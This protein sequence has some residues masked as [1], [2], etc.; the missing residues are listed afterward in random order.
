VKRV[1]GDV[2]M[3]SH[4]LG[5]ANRADIR[6]LR[7][8]E[9]DNTALAAKVERQ[10]RQLHDGF[11][12]RDQVIRRLTEMLARQSGDRP[13]DAD[14][15]DKDESAAADSLL[16][17]LNQRLAGETAR[18]ERSDRR[19]TE[20]CETL[21]EKERALA[22]SRRECELAQ[23]ELELVECH[24][25][26]LAP[27][28]ANGEALDLSG[29]TLLYVGGRAHQVPRMKE[30]IEGLGARFLHHDGGIEHRSGLLPG[31]V[32]RADR[33]YFPIDCVSH[34]AALTIKRL[35]RLSDKAY[36]PLR[37]ASL[38]CLLSALVRS[39]THPMCGLGGAIAAE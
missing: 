21:K 29:L 3:L 19:L 5:A 13:A 26:E 9:Q 11:A 34:D 10:Q 22:A 37:T 28:Q 31:L 24:L 8:L 15:P 7:Q 39:R 33:V 4:L 17:D 20:L 27:Q 23:R 12:A 38:T 25:A 2:H 30:L 1:F 18:R 32:S 16:R 36:E 14:L 6:R 35:C